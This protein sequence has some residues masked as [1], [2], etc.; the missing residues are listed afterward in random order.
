M[1]R[2]K[3]ITYDAARLKMADL[4]ARA[5]HCE[6]EIREKLFKQ[7]LSSSDIDRLI[8][9]LIENR[10]IDNSRYAAG[11]ARDKVR[12][13]RW[14]RNK[15]RQALAL[16]R[17]PSATI[18]EAL[19]EIGEDDYLEALHRAAI[20]KARGLSLDDYD[21]RAKLYRHLLSRGFESAL[22]SSEI[23]RLRKEQKDADNDN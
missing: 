22:I 9:F 23:V 4:C 12:F 20:A 8:D 5:E 11:F 13:S 16:K 19:E 17:I 1:I 18:R 7:G 15:V 6:H 21:D 2:K 3:P 10:F 14:G